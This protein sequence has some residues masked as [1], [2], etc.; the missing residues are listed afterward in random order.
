ME[1]GE[2]SKKLAQITRGLFEVSF[3]SGGGSKIQKKVVKSEKIMTSSV[4]S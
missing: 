3:F 2:N 1:F 4:I